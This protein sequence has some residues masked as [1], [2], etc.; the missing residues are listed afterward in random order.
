MR[1][2]I[3]LATAFLVMVTSG[4]FYANSKNSGL[5]GQTSLVPMHQVQNIRQRGKSSDLPDIGIIE[6]RVFNSEE[7]PVAGAKMCAERDDALTGRRLCS[8]SNDDGAFR[9]EVLEAGTYSVF[10]SKEEA[11]YPLTISGFHRQE[12]VHVPKVSIKPGQTISGVF[13]QLGS[14]A[15]MIEGEITDATDH[16][17][18]SRVTITLRRGDN[19]QIYYMIG[20]MERKENGKFKVLVP[21]I[22]FTI[23]VSSLEYETWTYSKNG[24]H[25]KSDQLRVNRE[26]IKSL[27]IALR[28][29]KQAQ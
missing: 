2:R 23:E 9:L 25:G 11:G 18:V 5:T 17:P 22:P 4:F 10:G 14:K 16:K 12:G 6:G 15:G 28:R 13:V 27:K 7:Q 24:L 19:P 20:A 8:P 26:Q 29:K 21:A 1:K 3:L